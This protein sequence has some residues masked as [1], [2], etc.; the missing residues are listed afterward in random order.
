MLAFGAQKLAPVLYRG[1]Q[2]VEAA[3]RE[4]ADKRS[5]IKLQPA[6]PSDLAGALRRAELRDF[7]RSKPQADRDQYLRENA[8]RLDPQ[9]A[10]AMMEMPAEVSGISP[11]QHS[12]LLER[13]LEAT[14]GEALKEVQELERAIE[15]AE[16]AVELGRGEIA[17]EAAVPLDD[18]NAI[19]EPFEAR[20]DAPWLKKFVEG[21]QEVVRA[22]E[23]DPI[24]KNGA[25]RVPTDEQLAVGI[26][27]DSHDQYTQLKS[28]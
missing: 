4:V 13:A 12:A 3:K 7:L 27:A 23:W 11:L 14:H 5:Q 25:W 22:F 21:G 6:D 10:L 20:S 26:L 18:F 15:L 19:A 9:M 24:K 16:K 28:N 17:K 1:R 2:V 8:D